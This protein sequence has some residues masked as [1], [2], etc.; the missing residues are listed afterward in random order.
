MHDAIAIVAA[1]AAKRKSDAKAIIR[2]HGARL[3]EELRSGVL[4]GAMADVAA[5]CV[6]YATCDLLLETLRESETAL[7]ANSDLAHGDVD[8]S[9]RGRQGDN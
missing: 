9:H 6:I 5:Q 8:G 1:V 2:A 3:S 4:S 7:V